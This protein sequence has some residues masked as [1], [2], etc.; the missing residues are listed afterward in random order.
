MQHKR[1]NLHS[2]AVAWSLYIRYVT[3]T[4]GFKVQQWLREDMTRYT[5]FR[6]KIIVH[7]VTSS[8]W[9]LKFWRCM[10]FLASLHFTFPISNY[11][12]QISNLLL[13]PNRAYE[14][15]LLKL[16]KQTRLDILNFE[17]N[18]S[19]INVRNSSHLLHESTPSNS[20]DIMGLDMIVEHQNKHLYLR[21]TKH[22]ARHLQMSNLLSPLR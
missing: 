20:I 11:L 16:F 10:K 4:T 22:H 3:W 19:N 1:A 7:L 8:F 6:R 12:Y 21:S 18:E 9:V 15:L 17:K 2:T 5:S 13:L 14:I